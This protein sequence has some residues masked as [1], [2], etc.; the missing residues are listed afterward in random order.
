M[1]VLA[2]T[3]SG[4]ESVNRSNSEKNRLISIPEVLGSNLSPETGYLA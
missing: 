2:T 3:G 1:T 4:N